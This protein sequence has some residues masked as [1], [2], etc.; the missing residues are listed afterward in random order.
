MQ[1]IPILALDDFQNM[2]PQ[3]K[4]NPSSVA[5]SRKLENFQKM[6]IHVLINVV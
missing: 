4:N 5:P 2:L 3:K 1:S 6:H